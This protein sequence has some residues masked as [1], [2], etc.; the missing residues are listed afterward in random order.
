MDDKCIYQGLNIFL[1]AKKLPIVEFTPLRLAS[2]S[3]FVLTPV[4]AVCLSS[5][6]IFG[7]FPSGW[8]SPACPWVPRPSG[9]VV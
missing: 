5:V 6:A 9:T 1:L 8:Y 7:F 4:H 2:S 3:G